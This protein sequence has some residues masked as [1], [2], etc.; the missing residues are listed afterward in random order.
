M[1]QAVQAP[2]LTEAQLQD[3]LGLA[4]KSD[5]VELKLTVP[6][7]AYASTAHAL[8]MDPLEAQIRQVFF[9]DTPQLTLNHAGLVVRARRISGGNDD[10]TVKLRPVDPSSLPKKLRQSVSFGVEVD[11]MPGGYVC[12]GSMKGEVGKR[13]VRQVV[14]EARPI[15]KLFNADQRAFYKEHAPEGLEL[16]HLAIL[17]PVNVLKL[18]FKP[19]GANIP[20]VAEVWLFPN[21]TSTL[22]LST[23]CPPA[24]A[25]GTA[26]RL[27]AY[28]RGKDVPL[29]G[30]QSTKTKTALELF[31]A[32]L[33]AH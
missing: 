11:A 21:N 9:F 27:R 7:N 28:L 15:S 31:S 16:D 1:A 29:D 30:E 23:K 5:S 6:E 25:L 10:S 12:S 3:M 26:N 18:K 13:D 8:G 14:F 4:S 19:K 2:H 33:V 32:R 22:E 17:G 24:D 20:L